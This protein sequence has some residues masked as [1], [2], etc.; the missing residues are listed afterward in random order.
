MEP[1]T[2]I[3]SYNTQLEAELVLAK[4]REGGI[5]GYLAADNLGGTFPMMQMITGGYKVMVP[6]SQAEEAIEIAG[7]DTGSTEPMERSGRSALFRF[8]A[9]RSPTQIVAVIGLVSASLLGV[10]YA[11]TQGTL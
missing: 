1:T 4:L 6:E 9:A 5:E 10:V 2:E 3:A 8:L 7:A 11:V